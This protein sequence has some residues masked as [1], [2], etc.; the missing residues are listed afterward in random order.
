MATRP[1]TARPQQGNRYLEMIV[2][3][4][5]GRKHKPPYYTTQKDRLTDLCCKRP[6]IRRMAMLGPP[7]H[8]GLYSMSWTGV[9][10][11]RLFLDIAGVLADWNRSDMHLTSGEI[12]RRSCSSLS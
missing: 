8:Y 12:Q 7:L 11:W 10:G 5:C 9:A 2:A 4:T 1:T 3:T 6:V